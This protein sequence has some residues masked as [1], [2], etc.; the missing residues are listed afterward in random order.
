MNKGQFTKGFYG[1]SPCFKCKERFVTEAVERCHNTCEK[2]K[3]FVA[4]KDR[5]KAEKVAD[6]RE[7]RG[8]YR[9]RKVTQT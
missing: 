8:Y 5:V 4:E 6:N 3:S 7:I 1:S 2:Y 9:S